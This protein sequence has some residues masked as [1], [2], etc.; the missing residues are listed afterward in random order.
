M[1]N[2]MTYSGLL[3]VCAAVV[4]VGCATEAKLP[5]AR[6]VSLS[7]F[8]RPQPDPADSTSVALAGALDDKPTEPQEPD[9]LDDVW[10]EDF[11][12]R[13][14]LRPT[15]PGE[16]VIVD[17]LV[18]HINGR[19]VFAD[20]FLEPIE[21]RL[22]READT[23]RGVELESSFLQIINEWLREVVQNELIL[24]EAQ[25]GLTEQE[26]LGLFAWLKR[27]YNEEIREGGGTRSG[28]ERRRLS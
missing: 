9:Q 7:D 20:E 12:T 10:F 15:K 17:S 3:V 8:A 13:L 2:A 28:A 1:S 26:Q 6:P 22:L 4:T 24:A 18:G 21:D 5:K 14:T 27:V 23:K 11:D 19:P 25:A 16:K